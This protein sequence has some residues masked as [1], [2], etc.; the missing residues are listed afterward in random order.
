LSTLPAIATCLFGVFAG[1]RLKNQA[2]ADRRKA[3]FLLAFGATGVALGTL[4]GIQ[5]PVIKK[6]WTSSY[7]LVAG[8]YSAMLLGGF[9]LVIDIWKWQ[10]WCRPFVWLGMNSITLYL[11]AGLLGEFTSPAERLVGGD[12]KNFFD[13]QVA[14][15]F[16]GLMIAI[17]GLLLAF[18][19]ARFLYRR[20]I[21]LR[22]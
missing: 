12:I 16:G 6:I 10:R 18:G 15:G 3:V 1:L 17:V 14:N 9:Y 13:A 22:L 19:F 20:N 11:T 4:W 5:F 2:V 7:V 8:G 21:F